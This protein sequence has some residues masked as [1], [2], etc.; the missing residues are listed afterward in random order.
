M[1]RDALVVGINSYEQLPE[2][3][4]L[5]APANDAE[6]I[7]QRLEAQGFWSVKRLPEATTKSG[8]QRVSS[9]NKLTVQELKGSYF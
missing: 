7:A 9:K 2:D 5:H 4:Q 6:L 1:I 3:R 8:K